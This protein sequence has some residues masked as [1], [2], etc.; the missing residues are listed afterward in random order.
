MAGS[1]MGAIFG[2][3]AHSRVVVRR[4]FIE[5]VEDGEDAESRI[6]DGGACWAHPGVLLRGPLHEIDE[7]FRPDPQSWLRPV[8]KS[9]RR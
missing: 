7:G 8:R 3:T 4:T 1:N 2:P 6:R 9:T 5:V